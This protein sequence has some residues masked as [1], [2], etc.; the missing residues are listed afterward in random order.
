MKRVVTLLVV[1]FSLLVICSPCT[2]DTTEDG[3]SCGPACPIPPIGINIPEVVFEEVSQENWR[4]DLLGE[5]WESKD[6]DNPS[7]KVMR[8]NVSQECMVL[9]IKESTDLSLSFYAIE[10]I[11]GFSLRSKI[12][13][14]NQVLLNQ[15]KFIL[16]EGIIFDNDKF[17]S[18]NTVKDD[19][20]YSFTCFYS[21]KFDAGTEQHD[22]CV[23]IAESLQIK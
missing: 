7:I 19:F 2:E 3:S 16:L 15:Q 23:E 1:I 21:P 9:L 4:F 5:D 6:S 12:V 20:G 13:A 8:R 17:L 11:K 22:L 10:S 18:W 14:I